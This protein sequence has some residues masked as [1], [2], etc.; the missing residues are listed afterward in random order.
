[1]ASGFVDEKYQ[2]TISIVGFT[3]G[4]EFSLGY[5]K[6][7]IP[8]LI[9]NLDSGL[10][11]LALVGLVNPVLNSVPSV[12]NWSFLHS[13]DELVNFFILVFFKKFLHLKWFRKDLI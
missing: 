8:I 6:K 2:D 13:L 5:P 12:E 11:F 9:S 1:M 3:S 4:Y 7:A 10:L